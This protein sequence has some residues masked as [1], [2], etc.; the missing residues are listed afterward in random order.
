M[1]RH[2]FAIGCT[3]VV[4]AA[5]SPQFSES[6]EWTPLG[7]TSASVFAL[8][9]SPFN[10]Q[11]MMVG[12]YFGGIYRTVDRGARWTHVPSPFSMAPV[13]ALAYDERNPGTL[14]AG[15]F[16]RGIYKTADDGQSWTE[17]N[18]GLASLS[19]SDL[20]IDPFDSERILVTTE[21]GVFRS[22]DR[23]ASWTLADG[24]SGLS[25][26]SLAF[27]PTQSGLVYMGTLRGGAYRS[28]DGGQTW[29]TWN[30]GVGPH[31][32]NSLNF[33][34]S[35][36]LHA[37]TDNGVFRLSEAAHTWENISYDLPEAP[38]N[39]IIEHPIDGRLFAATNVGTYTLDVG[40]GAQSW[41]M[42]N[43]TPTR[44]IS[45]EPSGDFIYLA[46]TYAVLMAT[47]D[48]GQS[49]FPIAQG[50]QNLFGGSLAAVNVNGTSVIYSGSD[51]GI[52]FTSE[53]F[54]TGENLPWIQ[55]NGFNQGVFGIAIHPNDPGVIYAGTERSG[56]WRSSDWGSTWN[57]VSEGIVPPQI[58][59]LSQSP[60]GDNTL[61][62][63]TSTGLY[64]SRDD[65]ETWVTA[66]NSSISTQIL[67]VLADPVLPGVAYFAGSDG[68]VYKTI[69]DGFTFQWIGVGLPGDN[70]TRLA[71][72]P[73][74]NL[75]A[76]T[77]SGRLYI[78][79][80]NGG[81]WFAGATEVS[82]T[83][84]SVATDPELPWIA[85]IGTS[86]GGVYR[87]SSNG[88][89]WEA[90]NDGL[91]VPYVFHLSVDPSDGDVI[92]AGTV[93]TIFKST[94]GGDTWGEF[95]NGLPEGFVEFMDVHPDNPDLLF[96]SI[97]NAGIYKSTDGG[98]GWIGSAG[99]PPFEGDIPVLMSRSTPNKVFVGSHIEGVFSS[100]DGGQT[101][102]RASTGMSL[103]VRS[104]KIDPDNPEILFAGSLGG[105]VFRTID[106]AADWTNVGLGDR[107]IFSIVLDPLS[108][109]TV[110]AAT[111]RG[112]VRSTDGG[113]SWV[114]L[115]QKTAFVLSMLVDPTDR[116]VVYIG[117]IAGRMFKSADGGSTWMEIGE[118]LPPANIIAVTLD[119]RDGTALRFGRTG[120]RLSQ[121]RRRR[122]MA[123]H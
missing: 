62:A 102:E 7:P 104:V 20:A 39:Q 16:E 36:S 17:I 66:T 47:N 40:Q 3:V 119:P 78:S 73:F 109:S 2:W 98:A 80:D 35:G 90:I 122:N 75:Y 50:I 49:F 111:S 105:G 21:S 24:T 60:V 76:V 34:G 43:E 67:S 113:D 116:D 95:G 8:A 52:H 70:V 55:S 110:Y 31:D 99:G 123:T 114:D 82:E 53:S 11:E 48:D 15:T 94:D 44:L 38:V 69:D 51:Q 91:T 93:D 89:S 26:R 87:S 32:V 74:G 68:A 112:V 115:G 14:Y 4:L 65:G 84:L 27:D 22:T 77:T 6:A 37:S 64:I 103:F 30:D 42:W 106:G 121:L 5:S 101:Y 71:S 45:V 28:L 33:D 12:T 46:G 56:V 97:K 58:Y 120:G 19:I 10:P 88:I 81:E 23:G 92:Y 86:E 54:R 85:Y 18:D 63:G 96:A 100:L 59:S 72:A 41:L 83:V 9:R 108:S 29:E 61:Y 25:T 79:F 107:N 13:F 117:S 57:Q 1:I 118:G